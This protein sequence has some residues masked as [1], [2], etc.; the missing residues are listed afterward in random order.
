M[1]ILGERLRSR[2][3]ELELSDAEVARRAG[4]GARRYGHYVAGNREP[5]LQT[6]IR[7]CEVLATTPNHLLGFEE[8]QKPKTKEARERQKQ[9]AKLIAAS[10]ILEVEKLRLAVKQVEVLTQTEA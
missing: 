1:G 2:A 4:L 9:Q 8:T 10:N 3:K 6:L 5:D 7:I